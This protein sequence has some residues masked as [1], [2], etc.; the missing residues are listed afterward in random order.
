MPANCPDL[1]AP[2]D[3]KFLGLNPSWTASDNDS[4]EAVMVTSPSN[5]VSAGSLPTTEG[6]SAVDTPSVGGDEL[7]AGLQDMT[8]DQEPT[9]PVKHTPVALSMWEAAR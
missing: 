5:T 3:V 9:T 6:T 2:T 7:A 1:L 8:V 4:S